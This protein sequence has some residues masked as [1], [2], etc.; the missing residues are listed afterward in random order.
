MLKAWLAGVAL[1]AVATPA[2]AVTTTT[3]VLDDFSVAQALTIDLA[4]T[5]PD[6]SPTGSTV[7]LGVGGI[8][9][10]MGILPVAFIAPVSMSAISTG[11]AGGFLDITN[12]TGEDSDII[13]EYNL[14]GFSGLPADAINLRLSILVGATGPID[15]NSVSVA[16]SYG[17]TDLGLFNFP[18][19]TNNQVASF[20]IDPLLFAS[21]GTLRF[22]LSGQTGWDAS[23]DN[24]AFSYD[25]PDIDVSEPGTVAL[26]GAGLLGL[27]LL[28]RRRA[29]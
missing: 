6:P 29:R 14:P 4:T 1:A 19:N 5:P 28:R 11:G 27:G 13:I 24:I 15:G 8:N 3:V 23:F 25:Q 7:P 26:L 17:G 18:G 9:R 20:A 21:S 12:G 10:S 22:V 16:L 2:F